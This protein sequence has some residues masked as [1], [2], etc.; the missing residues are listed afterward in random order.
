[1]YSFLSKNIKPIKGEIK[2]TCED[3]IVNEILSNLDLHTKGNFSLFILKKRNLTTDRALRYIAKFHHIS[4]KR[5]NCAGNKDKQAITTQLCSAYKVNVDIESKNVT[6]KTI[7]YS[8]K[9]ITLGNIW[10]NEFFIRINHLENECSIDAY[11]KEQKQFPNYFGKQR[12]GRREINHIIG[13]YILKN[14]FERAVYTFLTYSKNENEHVKHIREEIKKNNLDVKFPTH[15]IH[16]NKVLN[17]IKKYPNDFIG[18]L[19]EIPR[20]I[21]L[22]MIHAYQSYLFNLELSKRIKENNLTTKYHNIIKFKG[23]VCKCNITN[24]VG[25]K[26]HLNSYEEEIL[27]REGIIKNMFNI[28]QIPE[29]KS[30]GGYRILLSPFFEQYR[31]EN[32]IHFVLPSG[33]Y[34]TSLL[35]ELFKKD[36]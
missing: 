25:Y 15:M 33:T 11:F 9:K 19:R 1:M 3:F 17:H 23:E 13:R 32:Q 8:D 28:N 21:L 4:K 36:I 29:L 31:K 22:L 35:R 12:F 2:N 27:E 20:F 6:A 14:E 5:F 30:K 10:G 26:T 16:E 34:A 7:G 24:I 18:A